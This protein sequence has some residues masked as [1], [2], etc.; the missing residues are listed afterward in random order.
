MSEISKCVFSTIISV[1]ASQ[2]PIGGFQSQAEILKKG[3]TI[4]LEFE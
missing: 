1:K 2:E 3:N 4:S